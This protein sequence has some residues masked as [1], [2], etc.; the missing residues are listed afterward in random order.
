MHP[1]LSIRSRAPFAARKGRVSGPCVVQCSIAMVQSVKATYRDGVLEPSESL[2]LED[3]DVV[4]LSISVEGGADDGE[5]AEAA[6][7]GGNG[8]I[9]DPNRRGESQIVS[10]EAE[11]SVL[12]M[13]RRIHESTPESAWDNVPT[14]GARNYKHYLYGWP[15]DRG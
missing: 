6:S 12:R 13:I 14:D 8:E 1:A 5:A 3:G 2:D 7:V 15:K 10:E 11:H 4:M 9:D